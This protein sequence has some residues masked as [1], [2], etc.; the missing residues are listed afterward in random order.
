[1]QALHQFWKDTLDTGMT[2]NWTAN[3]DRMT[4]EPSEFVD[5]C[6]YMLTHTQSPGGGRRVC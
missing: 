6:E 3:L 1:M 2:G 5:A 4:V